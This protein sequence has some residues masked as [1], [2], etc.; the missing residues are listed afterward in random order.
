MSSLDLIKKWESLRLIAYKDGGGVWTIGYG[1]TVYLDGSK[2]KEGDTCTKEQAEQWLTNFVNDIA[3]KIFNLVKVPLTENQMNAILSFVYNIGI[4]A[5]SK[6]TFLIK[7]NEDKYG[8]AA[9]QLLRWCKDN[10]KY[11]QGLYNRRLDEQQLFL[12]DKAPN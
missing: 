5:F 7:L 6:S 4:D 9:G 2:V 3:F 11:V 10:G 12:K 8:E 1:T